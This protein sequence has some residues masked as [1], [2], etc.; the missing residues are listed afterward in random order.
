MM[1]I[2]NQELRLL[3]ERRLN[4]LRRFGMTAKEMLR[5]P[6]N[7]LAGRLRFVARSF[8]PSA[9]SDAMNSS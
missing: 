2:L 8:A 5:E 1:Q 6:E 9:W 7:H 4:H 3:G